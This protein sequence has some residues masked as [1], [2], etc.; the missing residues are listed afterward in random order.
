MLVCTKNHLLQCRE[1]HCIKKGAKG[2]AVPI[3]AKR[4]LCEHHKMFLAIRA[5]TSVFPFQRW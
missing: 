1:T 5:M 2:T 3:C 4:W